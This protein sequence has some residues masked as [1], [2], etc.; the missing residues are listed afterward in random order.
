MNPA[1]DLAGERYWE[2]FWR[3]QGGRRFGGVGVFH[4]RF[5]SELRHYARPGTHAC[6]IGCGASVWVP[7]L[8]RSGVTMGGIDYSAQGLRM[9]ETHLRRAGVTAD[10][11]EADLFDRAR[12]AGKQ[13]DVVFSLGLLEHFD[14]PLAVTRR[15]LELTKPGGHILTVV[16][17]FT[18][19]WGALQRWSDPAVFAV[20][21]V[22]APEQ[23]D[24]LHTGV[25]LECVTPGRYF[26]SFGPLVVNYTSRFERL[27]SGLAT[28]L[29]GGAWVVQQAVGTALTPLGAAGEGRHVSSHV[30]GVY[31]RP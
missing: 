22:Y 3:R 28:A 30:L 2:R 24:A 19:A 17:N 25:G 4:R 23:L 26:G 27:P 20:H 16:P 21:R 5:M 15:F 6:E 10:L 11:V 14:D 8:A 7:A 1:V 18:G 31:R 12:L 13:F 29:L 9:L